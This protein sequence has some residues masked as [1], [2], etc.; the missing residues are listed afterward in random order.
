MSVERVRIPGYESGLPRLEDMPRA[1]RRL[2]VVLSTAT[3]I[4]PELMRAVRIAIRPDL[5]V[6]AESALWFGPWA[7]RNTAQYMALR[8]S[9]LEPLRKQLCDELAASSPDDAV[10]KTGE[11]VFRTHRGLSPVLALEEQVTWAAV[12]ADAGVSTQGADSDPE[13]AVDRL[14]ERALRTAVE[15]PERREGLRRW[16]SGAWQ[17]FP[18]RVREA[19]AALDLFD[20]LHL[21]GPSAVSAARGP[22]RPSHLG[23]V[24]DVVLP[25]RHDGAHVTVGDP[26]WPAESVLVPDTQPRILE[27]THDVTAWEQAEKV[28][29]PR[30]GRFS[31][32]V[33]SVPVFLRTARGVVYQLGAPGSS[34]VIGY[35]ARAATAR[36]DRG[37]LGGRIADLSD[38]EAVCFGIAPWIGPYQG[39]RPR[40]YR[41]PLYE[42]HTT[43]AAYVP[44]ADD[45]RLVTVLRSARVG[46]RLV[47]VTGR[48]ASG[49]TRTAWETMR[50][51][52]RDWWV[53]CPQLLDRAQALID[54]VAH[55]QLGS[56]TVVWLDDLDL[57]LA[58]ALTGEKVAE[59]LEEVLTDPSR[60]PLLL[61]ATARG[62]PE[63]HDGAGPRAAALLARAT[64][65]AMPEHRSNV[66]VRAAFTGIGGPPNPA[67]RQPRLKIMPHSELPERANGFVGRA[68]EL[69]RLFF[70]LG[71]GAAE[72]A[73]AVVAGL[74]GTGKTALAVEAA[75]QARQRGWY[76]GGVLWMDLAGQ[77]FTPSRLL[78]RLGL[79]RQ[80][81]PDD[82][83]G[84]WVVCA[85]LL[86]QLTGGARHPV[87][88][89][90]D[91][92]PDWEFDDLPSL[93]PGLS[94]LVTSSGENVQQVEPVVLGPLDTADA[95]CML[96]TALASRGQSDR[97]PAE[98]TAA[99]ELVEACG[100]LPLALSVAAA[101][102]AADS[103]LT[104]QDL[105]T[106]IE[107]AP[108]GLDALTYENQSVRAALDLSYSR[109]NATQ[110]RAF[111]LLALLPTPAFASPASAALLGRP[112]ERL[113]RKLVRL[114][115]LDHEQPNGRW[116]M[117]T[118]VRRYAADLGLE[119]AVEDGRE[120][121]FE[122]L[123]QHYLLHA[124]AADAWLRQKK[125]SDESVFVSRRQ[126]VI[127]LRSER[128]S[129]VAA[130][131]CCLNEGHRHTA[132]AIALALAEFLTRGQYFEDLLHVMRAVLDS[133]GSGENDQYTR[134]AALN[135][136]ALAMAR[137]G[138]FEE[139]LEALKRAAE[140]HGRL[141][142]RRAAYAVMLRNLG[143]TLLVGNRPQ[144]AAQVLRDAAEY[145]EDPS[146][147]PMRAQVLSHLGLALLES[148]DPVEAIDPLRQASELLAH[149]QASA[150]DQAMLLANLGTALMRTR[151]REEA[152]LVLQEAAALDD[153]GG[154]R[155]GRAEMRERLGRA[156]M[157]AGQFNEAV[158]CLADAASAYGEL[159]DTRNEAQARNNL[160][161]ALLDTNQGSK[162]LRQLEVALHLYR[163]SGDVLSAAQCRNNL[164]KALRRLGQHYAAVE[165]L[166]QT[167]LELQDAGD[168]AGTAEALLNLGLAQLA[169][170]H[171]AQAHATLAASAEAHA[172]LGNI[173]GRAHAL[174]GLSRAA[175]STGDPQAVQYLRLASEAFRHGRS[176]EGMID[177]LLLL[178]DLFAMTGHQGEASKV[179]REALGSGDESSA[180]PRTHAGREG[181]E[182]TGSA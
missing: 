63:S 46:S 174:L 116:Q 76:P 112:P 25:V 55:D 163:G 126:A 101:L 52:L 105:V 41:H 179:L 93:V 167:V 128:A 11:V 19:P 80:H 1:A 102:L 92:A 57:L 67:F 158:H 66:P 68:A 60:R 53:W 89:V 130:V 61:L 113:L 24:G 165:V 175:L 26:T 121:A 140:L 142:D 156:L 35:P 147:E 27:I 37:L 95:Y 146:G 65:V 75:H 59:A 170:G 157:E 58:D 45:E 28:R 136:F 20:V 114:H 4:E 133:P 82:E 83:A 138:D 71:A 109:L 72:P 177:A 62:W 155:R 87:L 176:T 171:A 110:A 5:D 107:Q 13:F 99:R 134:A 173:T 8:P 30:G 148:G 137:T 152:V 144:H 124:E 70:L 182:P 97:M 164:G 85:A 9:L 139:A 143:A 103:A 108:I 123:M 17:R 18:E 74:S 98:E 141:G 94:V 12:L 56:Q 22:D 81:Q 151:Q 90:L 86:H 54:A 129:L 29:V 181:S 43:P 160:G 51:V 178:S 162:A 3:R 118:L 88:L 120:E 73:F 36:Q 6:G 91:D 96:T 69:E 159:A 7:H 34:E 106:A 119:H 32:P 149:V 44:H 40:D 104:L 79:L 23:G 38:T 84:Q 127:W 161:L 117:H 132:A 42:A 135:N 14:L 153:D 168:E 39:R 64:D 33:S 78:T 2:A 49:R 21:D 172:S 15:T 180:Q 47:V 50:R 100:R 115:L 166:S 145:Y 169:E 122:R 111:R 150:Q 125:P 48:P 10:R 131:D 16:F 154:S 31:I 77:P